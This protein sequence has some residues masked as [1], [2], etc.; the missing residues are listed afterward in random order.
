MTYS[1]EEVE[2]RA[3]DGTT[4]L[5]GGTA[6]LDVYYQAGEPQTYDDPGCP[7]EVIV[8]G[9]DV[10]IECIALMVDGEHFG[11]INVGELETDLL[12][13]LE[14]ATEKLIDTQAQEYAGEQ[15]ARDYE[16]EPEYSR[17]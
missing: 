4:F 9:I 1:F 6:E 15:D 3:E 16:P 11:C 2:Y 13:K 7:A 14:V 8:E 10:N 17:D 5:L 12:R